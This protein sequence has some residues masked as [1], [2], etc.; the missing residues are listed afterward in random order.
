MFLDATTN[1]SVMLPSLPSSMLIP[2]VATV[3]AVVVV[4]VVAVIMWM[5]NVSMNGLYV[6]QLFPN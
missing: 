4:E 3:L 5:K 2:S 1:Q 6:L